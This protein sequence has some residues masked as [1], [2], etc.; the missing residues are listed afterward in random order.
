MRYLTSQRSLRSWF[1]LAAVALTTLVAAQGAWAAEQPLSVSLRGLLRTAAITPHWLADGNRFWYTQG[2]PDELTVLLVDPQANTI[3]PFFDVPRLRTALET[4]FGTEPPGQGVPFRTF[5]LDAE[6]KT[7][8]FT[9]NKRAVAL[10]LDTYQASFVANKADQDADPA[11]PRVVTRAFPTTWSD[12]RERLSPDSKWLASL[13]DDNLTLRSP[14]GGAVRPLT[15]DGYPR[16]AWTLAEAIW[17][18]DSRFLGAVRH[19]RREVEMLPVTDW[20][21]PMGERFRR[22][23][24]TL[25]GPL[26]RLSVAVFDAHSGRR[27]TFDVPPET[28]LKT[29]GWRPDSSEFLIAL[30]S[31]DAKQV[32][33]CAINSQTGEDRTVLVE[34][35]DTFLYFPPNFVFRQGPPFHLLADNEHFIWGSERDGWNH[36][37]LYTLDGKLVRRLSSG[38]HPVAS[39]GGVNARRGEFLYTALADGQ[40]PYDIHVYRVGLETGEPV[41]LSEAAGQHE[42]HVSPSGEFY[43]DKHST[44]ARPPKV[45]LRRIDGSLVRVLSEVKLPPEIESRFLRPEH[46]VAKA[47]DGETDVYGVIF[48]PIG[49]DANKKYPVVEEIYAGAFVLFTPYTFDASTPWYGRQ[50]PDHGYVLVV[51]DGRGTPGRSK[52]FQDVVYHNL[53]QHEIADHAAALKQAAATR[54]WMDMSRVG[55]IGNSYGGYFAFRAL[56]QAPDV[57]HT[58]VAA[59][60]PHFDG[61]GLAIAQECYLG[62]YDDDRANYDAASNLRLLDQLSGNLLLVKGGMDVNTPLH[63]TMKA[64]EALVRAGKH[65][66]MLIIPGSN[67]VYRGA[68]THYRAYLNE[69]VVRHLDRYLRP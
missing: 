25:D 7:A 52:A 31:R 29:L 41:R 35:C 43:L 16:H 67:H 53:G 48:K 68:D 12:V 50:L 39:F 65:F 22:A 4:L 18:P 44:T 32:E 57:Y 36:F 54:P 9:M 19:D 47:A 33:I 60:F 26:T 20:Q 63:G 11:L 6:E 3:E 49:F 5:D 56:L 55:I 23:W 30:L 37:Y 10:D 40:R 46:F 21:K 38:Q 62:M 15:E 17:S 59:G 2:T 34:K 64:A 45:E 14:L 42:I 69:A 51:I 58:A 66:D 1:V 61:D 24:P 13:A 8:T 27:M 28:Y